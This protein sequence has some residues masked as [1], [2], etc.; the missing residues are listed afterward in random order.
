MSG[1]SG[2]MTEAGRA[3]FEAGMHAAMSSTAMMARIASGVLAGIADSLDT[4]PRNRSR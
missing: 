1:L 3:Q 2:R 4:K